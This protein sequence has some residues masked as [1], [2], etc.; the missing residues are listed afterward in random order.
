MSQAVARDEFVSTVTANGAVCR[1]HF[2]LVLSLPSFPAT[3]PGQFIQIAC[4]DLDDLDQ[5]IERDWIPGHPLDVAPDLREPTV[6]LRRP[7]SLAGRSDTRDG[8]E[9]ET[10]H[11]VVGVG[12]DWLSRLTSGH[13]V[14]ILGP[15][16]NRFAPPR[17]EQIALP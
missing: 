7:F 1:E 17:P 6:M 16:G 14:S 9:L 12:T 13:R 10:I 11:R 4:S 15:L 8:A 5:T 3:A 2:R